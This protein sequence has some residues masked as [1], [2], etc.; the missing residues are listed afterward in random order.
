VANALTGLRLV[1]VPVFG[2][3]LLH[4]DGDQASWR[5][6]AFVAFFVASITDRFDGELARKRGLVTD[7]GKIA[8]PIADKALT[9]MAL[10]GLSLLGELQWWVTIVVLVRE[11]GITVLR[12]VVIRHGVMPASRGGKVKTFAQAL[13]IGLYV[14]PRDVIP[15]EVAQ[16]VMAVAVVITVVTGVDYVARAVRLRRTSPRAAAKRARRQA[17]A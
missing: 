15:L 16:V 6:A 5:V 10:I 9:G 1:L 4:D 11:V 13:A 8:D 12:L 14:L 17:G 3:L 7:L 2:V